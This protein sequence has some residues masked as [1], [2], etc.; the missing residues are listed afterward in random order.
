MILDEPKTPPRSEKE[1]SLDEPSPKAAPEE[2]KKPEKIT[3]S[4]NKIFMKFGKTCVLVDKNDKETIE[5]LKRQSRNPNTIV[6]PENSDNQYY[7]TIE[8]R[9]KHAPINYKLLNEVG[10][11][12]SN[13]PD[14]QLA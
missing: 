13:S 4:D 5:N 9:R 6:N 11:A 12:Q 10:R 7:E 8:P 14:S 2:K 1:P 3:S